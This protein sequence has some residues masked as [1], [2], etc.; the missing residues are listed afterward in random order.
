MV[1]LWLLAVFLSAELLLRA[2]HRALDLAK[3]TELRPETQQLTPEQTRDAFTVICLG[4]S[5]TF[6]EGLSYTQAFPAL[7]EG[8]LRKRCPELNIAV[9]NAGIRGN[10]AVMGLERLTNDV[11]AHRPRIV[12]SAF[13]ANDGNLGQWSLDSFRERQMSYQTTP[14]GRIEA[15]L[16]QSHV[17]LSLRARLPGLLRPA[18]VVG[19]AAQDCCGSQPRVSLQGFALAQRLIAARL[20][21]TGA[22]VLLMTPT[23]PNPAWPRRGSEQCQASVYEQYN[24]VVRAVAAELSAPLIDLQAA[25]QQESPSSC[26]V[27]IEPDAVHLTAEGHC[28]AAQLTL[29]S[30]KRSGMLPDGL[31]AKQ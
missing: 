5:N 22:S 17:L 8:L 3:P 30:L 31:E 16:M 12:I 4:D 26:A 15:W 9:I 27:L 13:G 10:T 24:N 6:G 18:L 20:R 21:G 28:L 25:L 29:E 7:L 2:R 19:P 23:V 1:A 14:L 11:L